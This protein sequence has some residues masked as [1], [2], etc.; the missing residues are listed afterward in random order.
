MNKVFD[1]LKNLLTFKKSEPWYKRAL[2]KTALIVD[3]KRRNKIIT[4]FVLLLVAVYFCMPSM[5][6][7]I[8]KVVHQY[9]SQIIGT[10][11]SIGG[12]DLAL[13]DGMAMVKNIKIGN[14]KG[15]QSPYLFY[16]KELD[17]QIDI[18]S[19][20]SDTIIIEKINITAPEINY[21]TDGLKKS[22]VSDILDNIQKN[23]ASD[24]SSEPKPQKEDNADESSKKVI[25]KSL[26]VTDGK[27]AAILGKGALKAP[28][29]VSLPTI[30]MSNIGQEKQ[31]SSP[32]ETI[33]AVITK[34]LQ[35]ASQAVLSANL[36][37]LQDAAQNV[38]GNLKKGAQNLQQQ[39]KDA[40]DNLKNLGG[41]FSK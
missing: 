39:G 23:T 26:V 30:K 18:S 41:L 21:E 37:G 7:I 24:N 17:V 4:F 9:G 25:I 5:E 33:T 38:A 35:T 31:G 20:A 10:D 14:P 16:L 29:T 28:I 27:V 3:M 36:A 40:L 15:Y 6:S 32:V 11:V 13:S 12:V 34:I 1:K 2:K 8:K 19:L 22:N